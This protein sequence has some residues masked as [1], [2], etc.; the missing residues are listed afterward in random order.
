MVVGEFS[1]HLFIDSAVFRFPVFYNQQLPDI[2]SG[3]TTVQKHRNIKL[4][5]FRTGTNGLEKCPNPISWIQDN[6]K[7][8]NTKCKYWFK[9]KFWIIKIKL[10]SALVRWIV[11]RFGLPLEPYRNHK[12]LTLD[13]LEYGFM[14]ILLLFMVWQIWN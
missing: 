7:I 1:N 8:S 14:G 2:T 12:N 5:C 6:Y 4:R 11:L 10:Y 3:M 13:T 9:K